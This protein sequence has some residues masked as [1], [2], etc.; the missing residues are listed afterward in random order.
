MAT[1]AKTAATTTPTLAATLTATPPT[2]TRNSSNNNN[3]KQQQPGVVL[4]S[5]QPGPAIG[6][7]SRGC[8]R[9]HYLTSPTR[10][11]GQLGTLRSGR[12]SAAFLLFTPLFLVRLTW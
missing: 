3:N 9:L 7:R 6:W 12:L 5:R 8:S 10:G 2:A 11:G 4:T 1:T